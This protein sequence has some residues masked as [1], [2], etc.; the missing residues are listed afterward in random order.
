MEEESKAPAVHL[1]IV[2]KA[3]MYHFAAEIERNGS[4]SIHQYIKNNSKRINYSTFHK[5]LN[6]KIIGITSALDSIYEE[7][8]RDCFENEVDENGN[9]I[10][11]VNG[12]D[13]RFIAFTDIPIS[14]FVKY[15]EFLKTNKKPKKRKSIKN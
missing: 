9:K 15:N 5:W 1:P 3:F 7:F 2:L 10:A 8:G 14:T 13:N 4:F 6:K 11:W 12:K